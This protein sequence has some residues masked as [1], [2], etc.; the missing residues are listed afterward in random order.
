MAK[1]P[2]TG[3]GPGPQS[4]ARRQAPVLKKLKRQAPLRGLR[5]SADEAIVGEAS[6]VRRWSMVIADL[7]GEVN[8]D[9]NDS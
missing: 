1:S 2:N 3:P 5:C 6:W 9:I 7:S 8:G 4:P